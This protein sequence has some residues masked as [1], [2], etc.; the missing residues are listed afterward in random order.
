MNH[1]IIN[2]KYTKKKEGL[3]WLKAVALSFFLAMPLAA[4]VHCDFS[5]SFFWRSLKTYDKF[6]PPLS[7]TLPS[8]PAMAVAVAAL[9][10]EPLLLQHLSDN[11]SPKPTFSAA[12]ENYEEMIEVISRQHEVSPILVKAIIQAESGFNPNAVSQSG[13]VGLMQLMPATA[14]AMGITDL[15]DPHSNITAGVKYI[16]LL[17]GRFDDDERLALAAYNCGP[18]ALRRFG[19]EIPP[20][21]ETLAFV[22]KVLH[23]YNFYLEG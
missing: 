19:G 11:S 14:R 18:E 9:N 1:F 17:L 15:T 23:Y 13:A 10:P 20:F 8:T 21:K 22:E 2:K 4:V 7:S 12:L 3:A 5:D 6:A 16:K